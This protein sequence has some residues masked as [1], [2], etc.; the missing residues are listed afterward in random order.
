MNITSRVI[1]NARKRG[2][3]IYTRR[4]WGSKH[5]LTYQLRRR[6]RK[7]NQLPKRPT[8]TLVQHITVTRD[9]GPTGED[10]KTDM[11]EIER[12]GFERFGSGV[13]YNWCVDMLTGQVGLG[14]SLDAAGTHTVNDKNIPGF[15]KNLNYVS[16]A[17]SVIGMPGDRLSDLAIN[18]ISRLIA[19]HIEEGALTKGHDYLPHSMFAKKDCPTEAV[20]SR[21]DEINALA[22]SKVRRKPYG[23]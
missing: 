21:M 4:Q 13:S 18:S 2:V 7:H 5:L 22:L 20:R 17:I 11:R 23:A 15:S 12:I 6:Q 1:R 14:Q 10:F 9:D 16:I 3:T 8:D 19:A